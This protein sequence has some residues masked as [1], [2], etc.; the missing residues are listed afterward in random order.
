MWAYFAGWTFHNLN[1]RK[2]RGQRF[3]GCNKGYLKRYRSIVEDVTEGRKSGLKMDKAVADAVANGDVDGG[4]SE[5]ISDD[6]DT[7][8]SNRRDSLSLEA[9]GMVNLLSQ[10]PVL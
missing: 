2:G 1:A 9:R 5:E 7:P 8:L 3:N 6:D 4:D 10:E